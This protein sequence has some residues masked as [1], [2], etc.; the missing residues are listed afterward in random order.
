M[1]SIVRVCTEWSFRRSVRDLMRLAGLR[2]G[3]YGNAL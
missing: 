2:V 3:R 1:E